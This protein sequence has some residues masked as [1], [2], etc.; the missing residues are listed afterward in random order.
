MGLTLQ[1]LLQY[2]DGEDMFN[3]I[4]GTNHRCISSNPNQIVL[5]CNGN[6]QVQLLIQTNFNVTP[7]AG[8]VMLTVFWDSQGVLLSH[9]QKRD[10]NV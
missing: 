2:A 6:I 1:H 8:N 5:Q 3:R 4:I 7:S 9:V 10:E